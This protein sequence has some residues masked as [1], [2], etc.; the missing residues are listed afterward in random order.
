MQ[1]L[2]FGVPLE[3]NVARSYPW[4]RCKL[5]SKESAAKFTPCTVFLTVFCSNGLT[6]QADGPRWRPCFALANDH[7]DL[8][9][10]GTF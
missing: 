7:A 3:F 10:L 8:G 2:A 4:Q 9:P 6:C 1:S 5:V